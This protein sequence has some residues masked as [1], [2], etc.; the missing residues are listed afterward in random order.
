MND[1]LAPILAEV[2]EEADAFWCFKGLMDRM[3]AN[4]RKDQSGMNTQLRRLQSLV[5]HMDEQLFEYLKS[6]E[7][8]NLYFTFRWMLLHFKRE[9]DHDGI[10]M[11]W[12]AIWSTDLDDFHLFIVFAIL[13]KVRD[14]IMMERLEFDTLVALCNSMA[15]KLDY[16]ELLAS[17]THWTQ[18]F[19]KLFPDPAARARI[20][21]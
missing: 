17:A 6:V 5:R 8:D 10:R 21:L 19:E 1:L 12:E 20:L 4:F 16:P 11:V 3:G 15:G 9:L 13:Q 2:E 18:I 7:C 14:H